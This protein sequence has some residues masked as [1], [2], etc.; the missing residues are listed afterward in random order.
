MIAPGDALSLPYDERTTTMD[1]LTALIG[2]CHPGTLR[3]IRDD[4]QEMLDTNP[5]SG[6]PAGFFHAP[7]D[8]IRPPYYESLPRH[9]GID[10][11]TEY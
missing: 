6:N 7:G 3:S 10:I 5:D 9:Q 4:V 11:I 2:L 8:T 1:A